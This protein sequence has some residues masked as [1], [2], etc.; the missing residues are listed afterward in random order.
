MR[1]ADFFQPQFDIMQALAITKECG[2]YFHDN[3]LSDLACTALMAEIGSLPLIT[4]YHIAMPINAG[5]PNEVKQQHERFY[6]ANGDFN[7][8]VAN[9]LIAA[10]HSQVHA[11]KFEAELHVWE[12]TE[13]GYQRYR[14]GEDFIGP[15]RDRAS[16]NGVSFTYTLDGSAEVRIF[17]PSGDYWDYSQLNQIDEYMTSPGSVMLLRA[18][19]FGNGEQVIHQVLPPIGVRS[20]LNLRSRKTILDAISERI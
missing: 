4:R 15:H 2:Y 7:T 5:Q 6:T 19:G 11:S 3:A 20:I 12:L 13:I 14:N 18:K 1:T 10:I 16:D 17:E 8:P 9:A